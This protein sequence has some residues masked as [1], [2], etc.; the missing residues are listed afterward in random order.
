M[1]SRLLRVGDDGLACGTNM[2]WYMAL[3]TVTGN[4]VP[5]ESYSRG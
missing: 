4:D 2:R 5:R 3:V 1:T